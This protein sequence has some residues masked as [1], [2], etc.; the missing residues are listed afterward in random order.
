MLK[1]EQTLQFLTWFFLASIR[2]VWSKLM[3]VG[4]HNHAGTSGA[5]I[6]LHLQA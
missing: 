5:V 2:A 3:S 4:R 1:K 6:F